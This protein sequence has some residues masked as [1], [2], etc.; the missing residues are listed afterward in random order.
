MTLGPKKQALLDFFLY[1]IPLMVSRVTRPGP[2]SPTKVLC[3]F[4]VALTS[5]DLLIT[6]WFLELQGRCLSLCSHFHVAWKLSKSV[7]HMEDQQVV[8]ATPWSCHSSVPWESLSGA[9]QQR[10]GHFL[11]PPEPGIC[12]SFVE[13]FP[14]GWF[15]REMSSL[16]CFDKQMP[17]DEPVTAC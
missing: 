6:V 4:W 12:V 14:R 8:V 16:T 11:E 10:Y 7:G 15:T 9:D 3:S 2:C 5:L 1:I 13:R 17:D